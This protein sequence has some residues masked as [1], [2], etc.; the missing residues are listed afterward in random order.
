MKN[1]LV[2]SEQA[3]GFS[4]K[5]KCLISSLRIA[6]KTNRKVVL[7]WP[8]SFYIG[9]RFSELF[10]T[11]IPETET[12]LT[13]HLNKKKC[14][15]CRSYTDCKNNPNK[16]WIF[17]SWRFLLF[18]GE[19]KKGFSKA[20]PS[21]SGQYI[22]LEYE[23]IQTKLKKTFSKYTKKLIPQ[24]F[25]Q[26]EVKEFVSA[27]KFNNVVGLH[28]RRTDYLLTLDGRGKVSTDENFF[29]EMEKIISKNPKVKFFL[30]T[31]SKDTEKKFITRFGEKIFVYP[32]SGWDK[33]NPAFT[34]EA[35]IEM[36]LLSKT[37]HILGTYLSTFTEMAWWF[38]GAKA[39]VTIIGSASA[40]KEVLKNIQNSQSAKNSNL[41]RLFIKFLRA[42]SRLF[43]ELLGI[44]TKLNFSGK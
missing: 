2:F 14:I 44:Y 22:D 23:R 38:G 18:P 3:G 12:N 13:E 16:N 25:I 37:P 19:I 10:K 41:L 29:A 40:K 28:V 43:R 4:N 15:I 20:F 34:K 1:N 5:L 9:C 6:D 32:K 21:G 31:D 26:K 24:D 7:Y 35:L 11:N 39:K 36:L 33:S 17:N 27:N 30:A 42:R 8:K